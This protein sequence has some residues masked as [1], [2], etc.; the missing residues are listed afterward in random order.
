[1][2][3][4]LSSPSLRPAAVIPDADTELCP[5]TDAFVLRAQQ[6]VSSPR[7]TV[8]F[9]EYRTTV[10]IRLP[11]TRAAHI[12][13]ENGF[14]GWRA[15]PIDNLDLA[16]VSVN[17][18]LRVELH[19]SPITENG[20]L[21]SRLVGVGEVA[22]GSTLEELPSLNVF[23]IDLHRW[24]DSLGMAAQG[25]IQVRGRKR[26]IDLA[27]LQERSPDAPHV[28][29][30]LTLV[31]NPR[32][33][34]IQELET[35]LETGSL[36]DIVQLATQYYEK[37]HLS[38][39]S[40][41]DRELISLAAARALILT[42][43]TP[44]HLQQ[45]IDFLSEFFDR[46]DLGEVRLLHQ[47]ANLRLVNRSPDSSKS[48]SRDAIY[49]LE[50]ELPNSP[51]KRLLLAECHYHLARDTRL[52]AIACWWTCIGLSDSYLKLLSTGHDSPDR[53]EAMLLGEL[54]RLMLGSEP[55]T[56][57][58]KIQASEFALLAPWINAVRFAGAYVRNILPKPPRPSP[59][60]TAVMA[61]PAP[62][63]L[64]HEDE[65]LL[66]LV[67]AQAGR[68]DSAPELWKAIENWTPERFFAIRLLR[69]RQAVLEGKMELAQQEYSRL[70]Q[71]S[72]VRGPD[73][74]LEIIANE[75]PA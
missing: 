41:I 22:A 54:G 7:V 37:A 15:L 13:A 14:I 19:E 45:G 11:V 9:S 44:K 55:S 49:Q 40:P 39:S 28:P 50:Q 43:S 73:F 70:L 23:E 58:E 65:Q 12:T 63:I 18:R 42:A 27:R 38:D 51:R 31:S 68:Y 62:A 25:T 2:A 36:E 5:A 1:M 69:A 35:I 4:E 47:T 20:V 30:P 59:I 33:E 8:R 64:R 17:D 10:R 46:Q 21:L 16:T 56:S 72:L 52:S 29:S 74:F 57:T 32:N 3:V 60:T 71:E 75:R 48:M 34:L 6:P 61:A 66:R 67:L 53:C 26:W 24:R